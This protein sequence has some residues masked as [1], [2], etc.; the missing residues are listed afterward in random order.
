MRTYCASPRQAVEE[1]YRLANESGQV[2]IVCG[3]SEGK[4]VCIPAAEADITEAH[5][6]IEVHPDQERSE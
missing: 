4:F 1:A 6:G 5:Y 2:Y 3:V